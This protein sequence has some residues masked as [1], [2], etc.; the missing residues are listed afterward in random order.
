[1]II[2]GT[3][4]MFQSD[5]GGGSHYGLWYKISYRHCFNLVNA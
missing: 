5:F 4:V 2:G 1:M 3:F